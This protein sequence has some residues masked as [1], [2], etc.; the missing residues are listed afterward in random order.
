MTHEIK[1]IVKR[2]SDGSDTFAVMIANVL[3]KV[4]IDAVAE[5]DARSMAEC[6]QKTIEAYG[7]DYAKI[8]FD[9]IREVSP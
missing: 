2:L 1:I 3:G 4:Y 6:F 5:D 9:D 8:A 7:N